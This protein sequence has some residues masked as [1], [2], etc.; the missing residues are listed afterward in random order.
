MR[1][2]LL[3]VYSRFQNM[4]SKLNGFEEIRFKNL[5]TA[6]ACRQGIKDCIKQALDLFSKWMKTTDPDKNNM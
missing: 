2:L 1:R 4:T 6:E 5:V 3:P